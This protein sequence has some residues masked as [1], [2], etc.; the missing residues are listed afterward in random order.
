[1]SH[2]WLRNFLRRH[3]EVSARVSF[4]NNRKTSRE[5]NSH[6]LDGW[7]NILQHAADDGFL[8]NPEGVANVDESAFQLSE[9]Y[10]VVFTK[11]GIKEVEAYLDGDPKER[12]TVLAGGRADG[13]AFRPLILYDGKVNL[14][15]RFEGTDDGCWIST[16]PS[17]WM[18]PDI[19]AEYVREEILPNLNA[20]K[21]KSDC[22]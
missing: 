2:K 15:S 6:T 18:D 4:A 12:L 21:V 9:K 19:F 22:A 14:M 1:M 8:T 13:F 16:N 3:P 7:L 5:W 10:D 17:G 11:R 20:E